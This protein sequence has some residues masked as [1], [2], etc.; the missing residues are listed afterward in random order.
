MKREYIITADGVAD[1]KATVIPVGLYFDIQCR[2]KAQND[3]TRIVAKCGDKQVNIG[4]CIP[5]NG[6]M[7]VHTKIPQKRLQGLSGFALIKE[8]QE[9]WVPLIEGEPIDCLD[10]L[11]KARFLY[12]QGQP[13]LSIPQAKPHNDHQG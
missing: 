3:I 4:I 9:Q 1:G 13:G 5:Q 12:K 7:T 2:C 10:R 8:M 11:T 6:E